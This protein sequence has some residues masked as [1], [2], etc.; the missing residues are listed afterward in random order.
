E[1]HKVYYHKVGQPQDMDELIYQNIDEP[2][3]NYHLRTT[4]D[5]TF[6]ILSETESTSGNSLYVKKVSEKDK[7]FTQIAPGFE[8]EYNVIDNIGDKLLVMTNDGAPKWKLVMIDPNEPASDKWDMIIPEKEEVLESVSLIGGNIVALYMKDASS[9]AYIY[10]MEGGFIEELP[11]PGI[12]SM[13][14]M[15]GKKDEDI[16]F[17]SF[18]SFTFPATVYKFDMGSKTS[19]VYRGSEIDFDTKA[20]ETKQVFYKSKD[21]TKVPMFLVYKKG[22]KLDGNN[23]TYLYGYGGFNISLT[24]GFSLTRLVLIENGF[25]FAMANLRGG[26]EYGEEW[27]EAGTKLKKQNVFDDFIYAAEYLIEEGYTSPEKLAIAG[28]SN[29]G[30]LVGACMIQRPELFKVAMPAVGVMDMLRYHKFTIGWAW[31]SDYGT[32][33]DDKEMFE[34]LLGYSPLHTLKKGVSYPATMVSTADHDDRV[35]PAHSFKF[36]ATLQEMHKGNNPVLIRIDTKAG[37]GG[38]KPT[39]KVIE[40]YADE[41]SFIMYNLGVEPIY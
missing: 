27:H 24:P 38:G 14:G 40:E 13:S 21:G 15:R 26:G 19:E 35:V 18:T 28:G 31:A 17:Y 16:A 32:S 37:H 8:N 11:L 7:D 1:Y 5:E 9:K 10:N 30:L 36:A 12:G 39:S 29:G 22:L 34:Y 41:W 2:L 20:Y 4:E 33:E 6:L 23:P 25:V 3:R